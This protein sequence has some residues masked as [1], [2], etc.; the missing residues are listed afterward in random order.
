MIKK[1]RN[2]SNHS[3]R[4]LNAPTRGASSG[5]N[6]SDLNI[7][8]EHKHVPKIGSQSGS[9]SR[10]NFDRSGSD[11]KPRIPIPSYKKPKQSIFGSSKV[12]AQKKKEQKEANERYMKK[13]IMLNMIDFVHKYDKFQAK[14]RI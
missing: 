9:A 1:K 4:I 3:R 6:N 13:I 11:T 7:I 14:K 5:G 12:S 10:G 8:E 2:A